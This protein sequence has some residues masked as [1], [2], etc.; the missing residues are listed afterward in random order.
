MRFTLPTVKPL[1]EALQ[2]ADLLVRRQFRM[3]G[4]YCLGPSRTEDLGSPDW[5]QS[6]AAS[7]R[8]VRLRR[9]GGPPAARIGAWKSYDSAHRPKAAGLAHRTHA[10]PLRRAMI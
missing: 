2:L 10:T 7:R 6:P 3:V 4:A 5:A 9:G 8:L 1:I